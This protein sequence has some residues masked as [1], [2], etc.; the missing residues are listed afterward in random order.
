MWQVSQA[1]HKPITS[2]RGRRRAAKA[3]RTAQASPPVGWCR[4]A[5]VSR[6]IV[7]IEAP[8]LGWSRQLRV[9]VAG[10][11]RRPASQT[12]GPSGPVPWQGELHPEGAGRKSLL[13]LVYLSGRLGHQARLCRRAAGRTSLSTSCANI[14]DAKQADADDDVDDNLVRVRARVKGEGWGLG[15]ES[16]LGSG[17]GSGLSLVQTPPCPASRAGRGSSPRRPSVAGL[18]RSAPDTP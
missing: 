15:L 7:S 12:M 5:I 1:Y 9:S 2:P 3:I 4:H 18:A 8:P 13:R 6:A 16:G 17:L 11:G 10:G 14:R